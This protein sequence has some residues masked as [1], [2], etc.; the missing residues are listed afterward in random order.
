MGTRLLSNEAKQTV[1]SFLLLNCSD[2]GQADVKSVFPQYAQLTIACKSLIH[3]H[4]LCIS[5]EY[6]VGSCQVSENV[7]RHRCFYIQKQ[8]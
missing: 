5:F 4:L 6:S 8:G 7:S 1:P 2:L 3:K